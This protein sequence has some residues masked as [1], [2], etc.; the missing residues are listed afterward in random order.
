MSEVAQEAD[1]KSENVSRTTK[2]TKILAWVLLMSAWALPVLSGLTKSNLAFASGEF[3]GQLA[4]ISA[5][6]MLV[7]WVV[8]RK[9]EPLTQAKSTVAVAIVM[10]IWSAYGTL[11]MRQQDTELKEAVARYQ[12]AVKPAE[13]LVEPAKAAPAPVTPVVP[14]TQPP[15]TAQEPPKVVLAGVLDKMAA[16]S[17][18]QTEQMLA[19]DR[20][21]NAVDL[22][23]VLVAENLVD[24]RAI[25]RSRASVR[26]FSG[27]LDERARAYQAATAE[28]EAVLRSSGLSPADLQAATSTFNEG[29]AKMQKLLAD[30]D[31]AQRGSLDALITVLDLCESNLGQFMAKD[32]NVLFRT[33]EQLD[34]FRAQIARLQ[35]YAE[36]EQAASAAIA[37]AMA[38]QRQKTQKDLELLSK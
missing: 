24:G 28:N 11:T 38:Q 12:D 15:V 9:S 13:S 14:V 37:S 7:V 1:K 21:F 33:Q 4:M 27:L 30:L 22:G 35:Q 23:T 25:A 36:K 29:K 10:L 17:K 18:R 8:F 2:S 26:T 16:V 5:L 3:A 34:L 20:K 19:L 31:Q 32:G 6:V